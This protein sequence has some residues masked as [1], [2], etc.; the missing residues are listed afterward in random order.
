MYTV[1]RYNYF[2]TK[3]WKK[4]KTKK[5]KKRKVRNKVTLQIGLDVRTK[6]L[7]QNDFR[8]EDNTEGITVNNECT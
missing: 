6:A 3:E 5:G 8:Y 2:G 1:R 7:R 4:K